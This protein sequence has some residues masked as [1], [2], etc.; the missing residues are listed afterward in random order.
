MAERTAQGITHPSVQRVGAVLRAAGADVQIVE[1]TAST[2]TAA[3]AAAVV[4]VDV[5]QIAKS[6]LFLVDDAPVLVIASGAN[7]V[8][9]PKLAALI[10]GSVRRADADTVK[11]ITGFPVGGVPPFGH[12]TPLRILVDEDL[13]RYPVVWAA[14]GTPHHNFAIAPAELVRIG[15]GKVADVHED[16]S[17]R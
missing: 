15:G 3:E 11:R 1:F 14:A 13:L 16:P 2:R 10:G 4:G 8:S 7:R 9:E 6:L 12:T 17:Q 5:A